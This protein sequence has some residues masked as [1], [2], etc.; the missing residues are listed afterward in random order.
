MKIT[1]FCG[2]ATLHVTI[3]QKA[4]I[5]KKLLTFTK[6]DGSSSCSWPIKI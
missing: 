5:V 2:I 4:V 3:T 1:D 6:R